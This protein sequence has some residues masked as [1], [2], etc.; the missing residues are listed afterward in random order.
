MEEQFLPKHLVEQHQSLIEFAD[1]HN[2]DKAVIDNGEYILRYRRKKSEP[3]IQLVRVSVR[4]Y[5]HGRIRVVQLREGQ[6][7]VEEV[8]SKLVKQ[9]RDYQRAWRE[10]HREKATAYQRRYQR[11]YRE[12]QAAM[13]EELASRG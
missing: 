9:A 13:R 11:Q 7:D 10:A 12:K 6:S 2:I 4:L 5:L 1:K 8:R 3:S